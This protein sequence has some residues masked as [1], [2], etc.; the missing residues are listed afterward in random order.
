MKIAVAFLF[1]FA[2]GRGHPTEKLWLR[3]IYDLEA[4]IIVFNGHFMKGMA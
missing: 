2:C 4:L 3:R 1:V